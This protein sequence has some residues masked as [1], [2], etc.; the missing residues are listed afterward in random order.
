MRL[1]LQNCERGGRVA[2]WKWEM[3]PWSRCQDA[4]AADALFVFW[5]RGLYLFTCLF[6]SELL[7]DC[8]P[9]PTYKASG[10]PSIVNRGSL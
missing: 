10:W 2:G 3:E 8:S 9:I 7:S 6:A 4:A 1:K 5:A